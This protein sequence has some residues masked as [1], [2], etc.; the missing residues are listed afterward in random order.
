MADIIVRIPQRRL[1]H[2]RNDKLTSEVAFWRFAHKPKRLNVDDFIFFTRPEG[3]VAG[4]EVMEITNK[5]IDS[6]DRS[7]KWNALWTGY[8]TRVFNP[9]VANINYAQQGY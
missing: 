6:P 9:P 5:R 7:G 4:A 1:E 8:Q 2:F 3:V